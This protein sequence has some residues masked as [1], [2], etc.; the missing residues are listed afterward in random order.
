MS[1]FVQETFP[2]PWCDAPQE[3]GIVASVNADRRPD[4][5]RAML[6][7]SF[8]RGR[9]E[10]CG[11]KYRAEPDLTWMDGAHKLWVL[12]EPPRQLADWP[13]LEDVARTAFERAYG[14]EASPS[15]QR[16]GRGMRSRIAFGWA[17]LREK[18]LCAEHGLDDATLELMKFALLRTLDDIPLADDAE[19]RLVGVD[20]KRLDFAWVRSNSDRVLETMS[21]S[22]A[23]FEEIERD[24]SGAWSDLRE[25]VS[26]GPFVDVNRLL[27]GAA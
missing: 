11:T 19:L 1:R 6:D 25:A 20:G 9:C 10:A 16:L 15:A 27:V 2:C 18:L 21:A 13:A 5:R 7:D 22:R 3:M 8:Q 17:G 12:V 26:A 24:E 4:M 23:V 14:P